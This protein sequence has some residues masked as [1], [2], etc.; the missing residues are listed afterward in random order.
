[1]FMRPTGFDQ[2]REDA[3]ECTVFGYRYERRECLA[4]LASII[5]TTTFAYLGPCSHWEPS[6][7]KEEKETN[8]LVESITSITTAYIRL[9][10]PS[11]P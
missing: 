9:E 5:N 11:L 4:V 2:N 3:V 1:M 8:Y 6:K 10:C 7:R